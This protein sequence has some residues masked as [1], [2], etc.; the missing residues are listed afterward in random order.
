MVSRA[1]WWSCA[2]RKGGTRL[3][4]LLDNAASAVV[5][6]SVVDTGGDEAWQH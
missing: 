3:L 6:V 2:V 4:E 1:F 5:V